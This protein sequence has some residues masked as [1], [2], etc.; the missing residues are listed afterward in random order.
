MASSKYTEEQFIEA[1]KKSYSYSGVCREIGIS[2]KGGN[3]NTV[4]KK[5]EQLN[6]DASHFTG[7][8]WNKGKT[9]ETHSS[10]KKKDTS[11]ILIENSGWTSSNIR[12][13]LLKE[14]LKEHKCECCGRSEWM[15]VPIPLELHHI[16]E[17]HYDNR[18]ENLLILCPNC[19]ALTDS[20]TNIDKLKEII[21]KQ[22]IIGKEMTNILKDKFNKLQESQIEK[23]NNVKKLA[24]KDPKYCAFCGKELIGNARRNKYCSTD[25]AHKANGSK[26]PEKEELINKFKELVSFVQVGNHYGVSDNAVRKWCKYYNIIDIIKGK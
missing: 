23:E 20:H 17:N 10:I 13:R 12:N 6:L 26:R 4:K 24:K 3:L 19:H 25:C 15:G 11:E 21:N 7:Q 1:V 2:P 14:G 5:I 9:S 8:G 18:L 16:N 22:Q